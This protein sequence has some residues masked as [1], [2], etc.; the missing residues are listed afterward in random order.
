MR[1]LN[2]WNTQKLL[3]FC[4]ELAMI[5]D[6]LITEFITVFFLLLL[7][8]L[9]PLC[10]AATTGLLYQP[11]MI[12]GGDCGTVGGIEIGRGN[13]SKVKLSLYRPWRPLG[14]R[15]VEAP[16]F[17]DIRL[18]NGNKVVSP[19]RRPLFTPRKNPGTHFC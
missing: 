5:V 2:K 19:T 3:L 17:S 4:V 16:T 9:S 7:V 15:E 10:T 14:L 11:Q 8:R 18:I 6:T 1:A 12:D 13:Q